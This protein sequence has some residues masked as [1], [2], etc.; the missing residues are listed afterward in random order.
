MTAE[1]QLLL[2]DPA[3]AARRAILGDANVLARVALLTLVVGTAIYGAVLGTYR[4]E[5][6]VAFAAIKMPIVLLGA[7]V[8][9]APA[10]WAIGAA[11]G[12]A[13]TLRAAGSLVLV[14]A[15]RASLVLVTLA[16]LLWLA[17][18]CHA[19]YHFA[20]LL[21]SCAFGLAGLV[22]LGTLVRG[23]GRGGGMVGL[24]AA[25]VF[26][27]ALAQTGWVLRPWLGRPSQP[28]VFVRTE[29]GV[30]PIASFFASTR[31]GMEDPTGHSIEG[32]WQ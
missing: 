32:E 23:V 20:S 29:A 7:L 10:V 11:G 22:A 12:R 18:D 9:T 4:G 24:V 14:A 15:G 2:R 19:G 27:S 1:F 13:W 16:P 26:L 6:Q 17:I 8:V 30:G 5:L 21:S 25:V 3:E 31:Y 28:V